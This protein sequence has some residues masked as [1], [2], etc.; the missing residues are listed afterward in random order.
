MRIVFLGDG[1]W[2]TN[3]LQRLLHEGHQVLAVVLRRRP[4]ETTLAHLADAASLPVCQPERIN[5]PVFVDRVRSWQPDVNISMSYDQ[6]LRRPFLDTARL[7]VLNCHAGKLPDYRGRN[8]INWALINNEPEIGL[9]VHYVDEG[10]DTGDIVVQRLLPVHGNDTYGSVLKKVEAAFPEV[11]SE[12]LQQVMHHPEQRRPQAHLPGTYFSRRRPGDEW[13]DWSDTSLNLYNKIRA[14]SVPGPG[15]RTLLDGRPLII[16]AAQYDPQW[17]TYLA[18]PGE[19]VGRHPGQ[20][21]RVKTGDSTLLLTRVQFDAPIE[22]PRTPEFRLG[23][24][25][26]INLLDTVWRLQQE[27]ASLRARLGQWRHDAA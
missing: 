10:I 11:L 16:W 8:V 25:F 26:G 12:A 23:T 27:V 6:I 7:G 20:G 21:V 18:T 13:L 19:V 5:D 9:T 1:Q 14:I 24:R 4:S 15:A 22:A 3:C 2:A 17:P